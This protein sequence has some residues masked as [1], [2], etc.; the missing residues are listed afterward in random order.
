MNWSCVFLISEFKRE[1]YSALTKDT[2]LI[3][4]NNNNNNNNNMLIYKAHNVS[5][6]AESEA[7]IR[8]I[9][10]L[11]ALKWLAQTLLT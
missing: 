5:K 6:Q 8:F 2:T 7:P 9:R 1:M 4:N 3:Y 11:C 10:F